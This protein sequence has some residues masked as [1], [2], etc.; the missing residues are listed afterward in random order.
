MLILWSIEPIN[1][2]HL[3]VDIGTGQDLSH[4]TYYYRTC[5]TSTV[6]STK[7][8]VLLGGITYA[9]CKNCFS[10]IGA[11]ETDDKKNSE[12]LI[13]FSHYQVGFTV[14]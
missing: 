3:E 8:S 7:G 12:Y 6:S 10:G 13:K 2:H 9:D 1:F 5:G 14:H 4:I 11:G